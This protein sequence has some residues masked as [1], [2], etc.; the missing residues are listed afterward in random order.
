MIVALLPLDAQSEAGLKSRKRF[1]ALPALF[2]VYSAEDD[3]GHGRYQ[4][5]HSPPPQGSD[6]PR[7]PRLVT[8]SPVVWDVQAIE[9]RTVRDG[10]R[11]L[12]VVGEIEVPADLPVWLASTARTAVAVHPA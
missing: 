1:S 5:E 4:S 8:V 9:I 12:E 3:G 2:R 10:K 7:I 11:K 6:I